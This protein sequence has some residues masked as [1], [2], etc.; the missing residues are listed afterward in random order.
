MGAGA[1]QSF[2]EKDETGLEVPDAP[3][4]IKALAGRLS[5]AHGINEVILVHG[6]VALEPCVISR[7]NRAITKP[8][9][10]AC[11]RAFKKEMEGQAVAPDVQA[12][13]DALPAGIKEKVAALLDSLH[14]CGGYLPRIGVG[15]AG[16]YKHFDEGTRVHEISYDYGMRM[17]D[18]AGPCPTMPGFDKAFARTFIAEQLADKDLS[19]FVMVGH[20][21]P[22][23]MGVA[24]GNIRK[25]LEEHE[26]DMAPMMREGQPLIDV[27]APLCC[28]RFSEKFEPD[29][30]AFDD[31]WKECEALYRE[32]KVRSLGV[33][34]ISAPQL[35][36]LL[37]FCE[38]RPAVYEAEAHILHHQQAIYDL[39]LKEKIAF[40]AH[41]PLGQ[42]S[43]L[44]QQSLGHDTLSP[45]QAALRFNL[46]RGVSVL[47]GAEKLSEIEED[48][49]TPL[50]PP[51][52]RVQVPAAPSMLLMAARNSSSRYLH[53]VTS[54]R[55]RGG[56]PE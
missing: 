50:G 34:N 44:D 55:R 32:G 3:D 12:A 21:D 22:F 24:P 16:I 56:A 31:V 7:L 46:D 9:D 18:C 2:F 4:N 26:A 37:D 48:Q 23:Q 39:C 49:A 53:S 11:L 35:E 52:A 15:S 40:L 5:K 29:E 30:I 36:R 51:V 25:S 42:G 41:T 47:P 10:L 54:T 13:L 28:V 8:L 38:I 14:L 33:C 43:V 27:Y 1:S 20:P 19:D 45:A 17:F 6:L